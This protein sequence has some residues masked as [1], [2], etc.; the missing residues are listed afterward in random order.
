MSF[1]FMCYLLP[2]KCLRRAGPPSREFLPT[3][4]CQCVRSINLTKKAVL[5]RAECVAPE[6]VDTSHECVF[7]RVSACHRSSYALFQA[8]AFCL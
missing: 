2:G 1:T 4:E 8:Y 5:A 3:A 7:V 6:L